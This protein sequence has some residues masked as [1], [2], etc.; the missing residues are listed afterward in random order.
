MAGKKTT[1]RGLP[2]RPSSHLSHRDHTSSAHAPG[3]NPLRESLL[4]LGDLNKK[5]DFE[6]LQWVAWQFPQ[7][8]NWA[9]W[10]SRH[11]QFEA[12]N[13]HYGSAETRVSEA[14]LYIAKKD[15]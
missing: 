2:I 5:Y 8:R 9:I 15:F 14:G 6:W 13:M 7:Y 4:T 12:L 3:P 1:S 11:L 10:L